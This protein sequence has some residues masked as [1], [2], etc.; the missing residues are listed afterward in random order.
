MVVVVV[1]RVT[2]LINVIQTS[3]ITD[4][5]RK[6]HSVTYLCIRLQVYFIL[7]ISSVCNTNPGKNLANML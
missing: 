1:R 7:F 3:V 6:L 2:N 5:V 4:R